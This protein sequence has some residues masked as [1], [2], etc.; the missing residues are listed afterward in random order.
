MSRNGAR[1][2]NGG[3]Q[4]V[5]RACLLLTE[6]ARHGPPGARLIDLTRHSKLSRPT[7]HRILQSLSAAQLVHQDAPTR[8]ALWSSR[9]S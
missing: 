7:A 6:I 2:R 4:T 8:R 3:A 9:P 1:A 5:D